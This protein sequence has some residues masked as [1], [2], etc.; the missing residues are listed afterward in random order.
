MN[1]WFVKKLHWSLRTTALLFAFALLL[2]SQEALVG[3]SIYNFYFPDSPPIV[4]T[5]YEPIPYYI[6]ALY[7]ILMAITGRFSLWWGKA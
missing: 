7:L 6:G 4:L 1:N 2:F 3:Q 5:G